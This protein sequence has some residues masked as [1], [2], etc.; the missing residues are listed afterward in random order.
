MEIKPSDSAR[1]G[2]Y[3]LGLQ[4]TGT[5]SGNVEGCEFNVVIRARP[6]S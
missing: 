4:V 3:K 5:S 2:V 6:R 1:P